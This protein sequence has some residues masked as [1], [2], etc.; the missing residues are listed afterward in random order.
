MTSLEILH[1]ELQARCEKIE[2][3]W[4]SAAWSITAFPEIVNSFTT[5]LDLTP[6]GSLDH[7][8]ELISAPSVKELQKLSSFSDLYLKLYDNGRFWVEIL[9]WWGSDINIHDHD[10]AGVQFQ[11]S[12]RSLNVSYAFAELRRVGG[13]RVGSLSVTDSE[14]WSPGDRSTVLP[15]RSYPHNVCHLDMPTVSL[16]IRT[17]PD[18][19]WG[20]Q[21]N[22]FP[23]GIAADYGTADVLFR[24]RVQA[25]RLLARGDL[26]AFRRAFQHHISSVMPEQV[27]FTLIKMIDILFEERHLQLIERILEEKDGEYRELVEAAAFHRAMEIVKALRHRAELK[28]DEKVALSSLGSAFDQ[29]SFETI[30]KGVTPSKSA[31]SAIELLQAFSRR[32][33]SVDYLRLNNAIRLFELA[34]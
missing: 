19:N 15:G 5:G 28:W 10:F 22:Y 18:P 25:L 13:V 3:A 9:N 34:A 8:I 21:W 14:L 29:I 23:P 12:G 6:F 20:P 30:T 31:S 11:L 1:R 4:K 32:F 24:K 7:T 27:L 2:F 26:V 16:L 17:H 33:D